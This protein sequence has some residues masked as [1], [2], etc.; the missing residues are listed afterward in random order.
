MLDVTFFPIL[1]ASIANMIIGFVWYSPHVFGSV[2]TRLSG[3][4]PEMVESGKRRMPAVLL[5][6]LLAGMLT[7]Y[8]IN[9]FGAAWFVIDVVGAVELA[10]WIWVGFVAPV[11]LGHV[12][13]EQKPFT[14]YLINTLYWLVAMIVMAIV[15]VL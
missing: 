3:V 2:W 1:I 7:A 9:Y 5:V 15:L 13:W 12:L 14:L 11:M 8:V 10:F 4:T 6:A